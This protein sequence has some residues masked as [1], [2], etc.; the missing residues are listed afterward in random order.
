MTII[1]RIYANAANDIASRRGVGKVRQLEVSKLWVQ[2]KVS[3]REIKLMHVRKDVNIAEVETNHV[4]RE[5]IDM[6]LEEA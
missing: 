5:V 2:E 6:A 4:T 3:R 1:I